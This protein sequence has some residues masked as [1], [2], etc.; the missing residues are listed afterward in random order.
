MSRKIPK[1]YKWQAKAKKSNKYW[2]NFETKKLAKSYA[3][4]TGVYRKRKIK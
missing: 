4:G 3:S 2:F 1:K